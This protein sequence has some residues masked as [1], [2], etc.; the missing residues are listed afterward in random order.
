MRR[1]LPFPLLAGALLIMWL[2]LNQSLSVGHIA[3]G[4]V[5]ALAGSWLLLLLEPP[6]AQIRRPGIILRLFFRVLADI[7]RSNLAVAWIVLRPK[8]RARVAGFVEI[9][10]DLRDRYGLAALACIITST[11]GTIWVNFDPA[12]GILTIHVLDLV[13]KNLWVRTIKDRYE[14]PLQEI[15]E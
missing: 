2:L 5:L 14:R 1:L 4:G 8:P 7:A 10:L 15:F 12:T 11:P 3:L 13:D 9:P 6:K